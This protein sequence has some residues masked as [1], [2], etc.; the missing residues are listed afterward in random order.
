MTQKSTRAFGFRNA[1]SARPL[2]L[3]P[4]VQRTYLSYEHPRMA[5]VR[6][7]GCLSLSIVSIVV[8]GKNHVNTQ[9]GTYRSD[10]TDCLEYMPCVKRADAL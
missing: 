10:L 2:K 9:V 1:I 5:D 3:D 6:L 7:D 8:S 4:A